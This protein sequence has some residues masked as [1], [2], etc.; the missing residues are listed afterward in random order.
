LYTGLLRVR[1]EGKKAEQGKD[2]AFVD[3]HIAY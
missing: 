1:A 2:E 3:A